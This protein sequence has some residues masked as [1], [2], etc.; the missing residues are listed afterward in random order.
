MNDKPFFAALLAVIGMALASLLV[1]HVRTSRGGRLRIV[2]R[3]DALPE[4][5][6]RLGFDDCAVSRDAYDRIR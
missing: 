5:S 4:A 3:A 2:A 6:F 1:S